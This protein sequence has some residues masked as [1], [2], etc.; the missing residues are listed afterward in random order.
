M[1]KNGF[2]IKYLQWLMCQK[3]KSYFISVKK[4][5]NNLVQDLNLDNWIHFKQR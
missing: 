2:G 5:A 4:N 3:N 1:Y